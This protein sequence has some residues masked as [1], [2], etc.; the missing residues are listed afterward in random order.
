VSRFICF[1]DTD[2]TVLELV[3][4]TPPGD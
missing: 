3:E 1:K 2:G 4:I